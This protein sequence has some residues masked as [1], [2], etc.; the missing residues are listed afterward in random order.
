M[1]TKITAV[2][3]MAIGLAMALAVIFFCVPLAGRV[4]A[5]RQELSKLLTELSGAKI[6]VESLHNLK[7]DCRLIKDAE[8]P[9][10]INAISKKG[11]ELDVEIKSLDQTEPRIVPGKCRA[12]P[13]TIKAEARYDAIGKFIAALEGLGGCVITIDSFKIQKSE[14]SKL[15]VEAAMTIS[16]YLE[17]A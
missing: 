3:Y 8:V 15:T 7:E 12:L 4:A 14:K 16:I 6:A 10:V 1:K 2:P 9:S 13:I 5:K 11:R 17:P